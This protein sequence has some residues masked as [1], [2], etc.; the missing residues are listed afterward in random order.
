[1]GNQKERRKPAQY[2][3]YSFGL[4][5]ALLAFLCIPLITLAADTAPDDLSIESA[6]TTRNLIETGDYLFTVQFEVDW[7]SAASYP[8]EGAIDQT[9]LV[10][11]I[12][13]G[14]QIATV[15][16]Y[17]FYNDGYGHGVVS[18]YFSGTAAAALTWGSPYTVRIT[19]PRSVG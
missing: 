3:R 6:I 10:Q 14:T 13:S 18:F 19:S 1:M 15:A 2:T 8:D 16:P 5:A 17:P 12:D 4:I 11:L 9:F 7:D